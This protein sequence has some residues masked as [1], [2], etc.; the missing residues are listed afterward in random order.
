MSSLGTMNIKPSPLSL[1]NS[2]FDSSTV[3]DTTGQQFTTAFES[4]VIG[5]ALISV[6]SRRLRVNK[7]FC[8][9]LG[10][11]EAELLAL[12]VDETTHPDEVMEGLSQ[13]ASILAGDKDSY[14]R[15][16][17]FVHKLGHLVWGNLICSLVRANDGTPLHFITQAQDITE[18]KLAEQALRQSEDRFRSLT[19]LSSDWFWEQDQNFRFIGFSGSELKGYDRHDQN[20]LGKCRWEIHYLYPLQ[21]TWQQHRATLEAHQPFRDFEYVRARD[22]E[23]AV[24]VSTTG[25]PVFDGEGRFTGYR[26]TARDI[27]ESKLAAQ[28]L[29]ETQGM[30]NMAAQIGRLGAWAFDRSRPHVTWSEEVCAI[31]EVRP[32]YQ[33]TL[34]QA[35]E[36]YAPEYR[37]AMRGVLGACL[38]DGSPFDV[39][40]QVITG[41]GRRLWVRVIAEAEWDAQGQVRRIQGAC[42]DISESKQAAE[43]ARAVADQLTATLESLTDAFFTLDRDWRFTYVNAGAERLLRNRRMLLLG[44]KIWDAFPEF[45]GSALQGQ[46]DQALALN[47]TVQ[48]DEY[49]QPYGIWAQIKAYPSQQGLAIYIK[50]NT[51]RVAAQREILRLN[52]ELEERVLQRTVQLAAANKELESFSY[53]IAHD[54]RAPLSSVEGFSQMLEQSAGNELS[55]RRRHYLNRIR[56]GVKQMGELIDGLLALANLSRASLLSEPVNLAAL[57]R[58]AIAS[59]RERDPDRTARVHIAPDLPVLGDPRLLSQVIGN[60]VGNAW[61]FTSKQARADIEVGSMMGAQG[62]TVYFVRDNGAGFDMAYASKMFEA[63]QRMHTTA[64]FEGTGIGLAIVQKIVTR[65]GGRIW[66]ESMP[67]QGASFYFTLGATQR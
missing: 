38:R 36:F 59:C 15:E 62:G 6:D 43:H 12:T 26:G 63:F 23:P 33:P 67:Q 20:A 46:F 40:A 41:K 25:E 29:R 11:T 51:E 10:Y 58:D 64:E 55:D 14:Q 48:F 45:R 30:L 31:H 8:D 35:G 57:A 47:V 49:F 37:E 5:M 52:A 42:Q 32:G 50:D 16:K 34:E 3:P 4:A 53:S 54:L 19:M 17:R 28:Q 24:Y 65:H 39:E 21:A 66:A 22:N 44:R 2:P 7:A 27:T 9:M 13:R 18:R 61:K 60:L 56:A 1:I